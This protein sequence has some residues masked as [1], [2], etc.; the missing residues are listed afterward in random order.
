VRES[1]V[2]EGRV[3][4]AKTGPEAEPSGA[5]DREPAAPKRPGE[6][7][8][9]RGTGARVYDRPGRP[10]RL[11]WIPGVLVILVLLSLLVVLVR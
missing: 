4:E 10:A 9:K 3:E 1:R 2:R 8:E 7:G 11:T 6:D 5:A